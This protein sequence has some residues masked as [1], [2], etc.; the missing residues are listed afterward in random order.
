MFCLFLLL[1]PALVDAVHEV[2][3]DIPTVSVY[4]QGPADGKAPLPFISFSTVMERMSDG[5]VDKSLRKHVRLTT[6]AIYI[7][8]SGTTGTCR[9]I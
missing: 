4:L 8:T 7:F 5:P 9:P 2:L 1:G 3:P 6:P